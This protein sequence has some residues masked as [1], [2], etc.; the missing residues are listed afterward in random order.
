VSRA[1]RRGGGHDDGAER[2]LVSYADFITLLFA[3]FVVLFASSNVDKAKVEE[4]TEAYELYL[5]DGPR[6]LFALG[7][8]AAGDRMVEAESHAGDT[9]LV[10]PEQER[11]KLTEAEMAPVEDK[12]R[13]ILDEL[14][15]DETVRM[16]IEARGLVIS[17]QEAALFPA[18]GAAFRPGS[19]ALLDTV[20]KAVTVTRDRQVRLEG[21]TDNRPIQTKQFPSNW[22]LSSARAT[23]VMRALQQA[24]SFDPSNVSIAGYGEHRPIAPNDTPEGRAQ[25]RRVD[26]VILA[27]GAALQ[28]PVTVS[29]EP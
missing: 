4:F 18:G 27:E 5:A 7:P 8:H 1:R 6:K 15:L 14:L 16:K 22:E 17:L 2:W 23:E 19:E 12:L 10:D 29:P 20:A 11:L 25:N 26:I 28:E 24:D 3:F 21:H 13:R 9:E